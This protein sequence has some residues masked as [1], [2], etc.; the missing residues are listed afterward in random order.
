[1]IVSRAPSGGSMN[2]IA[3][4]IGKHNKTNNICYHDEISNEYFFKSNSFH[5]KDNYKLSNDETDL[6][7]WFWES[8]KWSIEKSINIPETS[9]PKVVPWHSVIYNYKNPQFSQFKKKGARYGISPEFALKNMKEI[10]F[11]YADNSKD[12]KFTFNLNRIKL[13]CR[14]GLHKEFKDTM[15]F[16]SSNTAS[17]PEIAIEILS[18]KE[19]MDIWIKHVDFFKNNFKFCSPYSAI[20]LGYLQNW[21]RGDMD[22]DP[23]TEEHFY[24]YIQCR[25]NE[26]KDLWTIVSQNQPKEEIVEL[27]EIRKLKKE[28]NFTVHE[29][30]Y[31]DLFFNFK[32]T[33]TILDNYMDEIKSYMQ[34]NHRLVKE[35]YELYGPI[36]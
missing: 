19:F 26:Y 13:N 29:I 30:K 15:I 3:Y 23:F 17:L 36:V 7:Y 25:H 1:M 5:A 11:I 4:L 8:N 28:F 33:G 31:S 12:M 10:F 14:L 18:Y 9:I 20:C 32:P 24:K 27:K 34:L 16:E 2:Y 21:I 35:Y 6:Y 22:Y